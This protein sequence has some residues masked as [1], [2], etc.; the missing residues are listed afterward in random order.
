MFFV[1]YAVL[2]LTDWTGCFL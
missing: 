2:V 1:M